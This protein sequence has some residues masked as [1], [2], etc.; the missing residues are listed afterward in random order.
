MSLNFDHLQRCVISPAL[1]YLQE[2]TE[3]K[4]YSQ[5]AIKMLVRMAAQES[6]ASHLKQLGGGPALGLWGME[7]DTMRDVFVN[8]IEPHS[9]IKTAVFGML[10]ANFDYLYEH[11]PDKLMTDLSFACVMAR[12][13]LWRFP[14]PLPKDNDVVG[15]FKYYKK[16]YN[17]AGGDATLE[18][19]IKKNPIAET[20]PE[21]HNE[22][23]A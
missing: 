10:P 4:F 11:A 20:S 2:S 21:S 13:Q 23:S 9:D 12:L 1:W 17:T 8:V 15:Q 22:S 7:P 14:E 16:R 6:D 5:A 19:W 18:S 3:K